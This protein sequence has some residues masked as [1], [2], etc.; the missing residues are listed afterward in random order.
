MNIISSNLYQASSRIKSSLTF[1]RELVALI[2]PSIGDIYPLLRPTDYRI[3][4]IQHPLS[5]YSYKIMNIATDLRDGAR[6][7]RLVEIF[8]YP[9]NTLEDDVMP[10]GETSKAILEPGQ[11]SV[12]SRQLKYP[13]T[14][15][16]HR[17]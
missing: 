13:C 7:T 5:E 9:R 4:Y 11:S 10:T 8:L 1:L 12:L 6:L 14:V 2:H 3:H 16:A 17:I 15:R